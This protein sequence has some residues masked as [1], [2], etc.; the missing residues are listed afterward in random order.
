MSPFNK[1]AYQPQVKF[2][3]FEPWPQMFTSFMDHGWELL[4]NYVMCVFQYSR[5]SPYSFSVFK[6]I[7]FGDN[8]AYLVCSCVP[9]SKSMKTCERHTFFYFH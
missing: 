7:N 5:A 3:L 1:K 6:T 9:V 4:T 2:R 8:W